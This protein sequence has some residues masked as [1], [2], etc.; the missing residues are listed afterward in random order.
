MNR[1]H[2][3]KSLAAL[4]FVGGAIAQAL[5]KLPTSSVVPSS[6][7]GSD[8]FPAAYVLPRGWTATFLV[9]SS[10]VVLPGTLVWSNG[11]GRVTSTPPLRIP[12]TAPVGY[13]AGPIDAEGR[14]PVRLL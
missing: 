4:P 5:S 11:D 6:I 12:A 10:D 9:A 3:L 14:V 8:D 2:L 1:R 7:D 13:A